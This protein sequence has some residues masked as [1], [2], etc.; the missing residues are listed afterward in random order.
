[1]D[2]ILYMAMSVNGMIARPQGGVD[3]LTDAEW[4]SYARAVKGTDCLI[5]GRKTFEIMRSHDEFSKIAAK[6]II[7]FSSKP[8]HHDMP[9][10]AVVNDRPAR[11][12]DALKKEGVAS[13]LVAGGAE[14][15]A[16]FMKAGLINDI[17]L[18]IEPIMLGSG[19][20]LF[21][22]SDFEA[23]L[24]LI[25][26]KKLSTNEIQLHYKVKK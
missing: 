6:R 24:E 12:I 25:G 15:N 11:V 19:I 23:R 8:L 3:F 18:D 14:L 4:K 10:V 5:V 20:R 13:V 16:S 1:M 17:I 7:I 21:A 22:D 26:T 2:V 9:T